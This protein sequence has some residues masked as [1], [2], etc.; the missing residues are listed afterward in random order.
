MDAPC[1]YPNRKEWP[2]RW[3]DGDCGDTLLHFAVR[4]FHVASLKMIFK[5]NP[6]LSIKNEHGLTAEALFDA[7]NQP[8]HP[9]RKPAK[10]YLYS[11]T[12]QEARDVFNEYKQRAQMKAPPIMSP[13]QSI[14]RRV[15]IKQQ[16]AVVQ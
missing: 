5:R 11:R 6:D 13:D 14:Q 3:F 9:G 4:R 8:P 15:S 1:T 10:N 16:Y 12:K 7:K 2:Y